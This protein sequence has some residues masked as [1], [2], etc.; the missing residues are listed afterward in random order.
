MCI[1]DSY[2]V[3]ASDCAIADDKGVLGLGGIM[4]GTSSGCTEETTDVFIES[5]Y[6]DPLT[7][8]RTA[9]R[10]GINSD[11]KYRF[12][13]GVDTGFVIGGLEMATQLIL[14]I[15]GGEPSEIEI[16]GDVPAPPA[17]VEFQPSLNERLTGLY[18]TDEQMKTILTDLG[19]SVHDGDAWTV[20]VPTWRR[21]VT[22]G[23]DLV[24][25][26]VRIHGFH[27]LE[28][29]SLP[30]LSGRREP[31]ATLLQNRTRLGRRAL[32]GLSL[33]HI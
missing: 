3:G 5:A 15:C 12:E 13:R 7:I 19:F 16:A 8:R 6:F 18:L 29:V 1:R 14:D 24:E 30:P 21:D 11:A 10:L 20:T 28:A 33:I 9:K 25:D 4:G 32:A 26:L 22:E 27:N 2:K 17:S 31:T 23:A